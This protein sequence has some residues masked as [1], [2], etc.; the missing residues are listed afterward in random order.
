MAGLCEG[1][2][3]GRALA[4]HSH[5]QVSRGDALHR[6]QYRSGGV[7]KLA[8]SSLSWHSVMYRPVIR[9]RASASAVIRCSTPVA[10]VIRISSR[11]RRA[12]IV[13]VAGLT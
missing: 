6:G 11:S 7:V 1:D 5:S 4:C 13:A 8:G 10:H 2:S 12:L 3:K 9:P